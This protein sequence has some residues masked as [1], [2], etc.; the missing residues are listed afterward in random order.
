MRSMMSPQV[1]ALAPALVLNQ[2]V[3]MEVPRVGLCNAGPG[4]RLAIPISSLAP[5]GA[6]NGS[7]WWTHGGVVEGSQS[8][9][10]AREPL[11]RAW[12]I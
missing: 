12:L 4:L 9:L 3:S 8:R 6:Q 1:L 11:A 5:L 7:C 2:A 10:S